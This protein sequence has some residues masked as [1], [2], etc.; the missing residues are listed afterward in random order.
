MI[1]T[2]YNK[3]MQW[4]LSR[5]RTTKRILSIFIDYIVV[6]LVLWLAFSLRLSTLYQPP[7]SQLWLFFLAPFIAIP[8]FIKL[9][10]YRAI[11]R[12]IGLSLIHI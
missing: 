10:L 2:T 1:Q 8:I 11:V 6:M 5:P 12:Y 9:G 3:L 7:V 4:F